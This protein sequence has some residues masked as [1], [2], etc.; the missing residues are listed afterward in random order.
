MFDD[1]DKFWTIDPDIVKGI[2]MTDTLNRVSPKH[3]TLWDKRFHSLSRFVRKHGRLPD[4][5][6]RCDGMNLGSW[7]YRQRWI[8]KH[9]PFTRMT[10]DRVRKLET[11]P[12]WQW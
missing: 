11:I 8:K 4:Y 1:K 9:G 5:N 2:R 3:R 10:L 6:Q 7:C 12:G